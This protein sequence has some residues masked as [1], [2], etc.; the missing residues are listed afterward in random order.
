[1]A[2]VRQL[3]PAC[4][5]S[6]L[7]RASRALFQPGTARCVHYEINARPALGSPFHLAFP[8]HCLD[9]ARAFYGGL[10]GCDEGRS[11]DKWIDF[12]FHGHQIVAHWVGNEYRCKDYFNPVDGD[13]VPVPHFGL[14]LTVS[15]WKDLAQRLTNFKQDSSASG[16]H[17]DVKF[18]VPPTLRFQGMPGEQHT[19]F[20]KDPSGNN[21]EFKAMAKPEL[22]FA[23]YKVVDH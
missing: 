21:L 20:L 6:V 3:V 23:K 1:M 8:V 12:S 10:L 16:P 22:L 14:V 13:E 5:K 2:L 17:L 7:P 9:T 4:W 11:S 18:I 15:Q 19:M